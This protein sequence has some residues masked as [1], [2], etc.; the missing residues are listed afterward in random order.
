ME[1]Q[2]AGNFQKKSHSHDSFSFIFGLLLVVSEKISLNQKQSNLESF[3][4][5]QNWVIGFKQ[6]QKIIG[7]KSLMSPW[8]QRENNTH[9]VNLEFPV[10]LALK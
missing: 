10:I 9:E 8:Q 1:N 2:V 6:Q 7:F 5:Q 3:I 4:A